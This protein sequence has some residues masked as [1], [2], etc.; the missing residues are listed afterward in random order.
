[1]HPDNEEYRG[2]G[3][4]LIETRSKTLLLGCENSVIPGDGSVEIIGEWAFYKCGGLTGIV[5]P[6]GIKEI[7]WSAFGDC[8]NLKSVRL[9]DSLETLASNAFACCGSL[10]HIALPE[11][12]SSIGTF[13]FYR[14]TALKS[15]V[16]PES[17]T[18]VGLHA[19]DLCSTLTDV[20]YGGSEEDWKN[21]ELEASSWDESILQA[22]IHYDRTGDPE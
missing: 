2:I 6:E 14:C 15:V 7:Q 11:G 12:L 3:N 9:P 22:Q 19:F 1:M 16:I 5:I 20:Y 17:V 18:R 13:C 4:C 8:S 10:E 21:I